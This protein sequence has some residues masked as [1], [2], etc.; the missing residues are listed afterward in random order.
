MSQLTQRRLLLQSILALPLA[1]CGGGGGGGEGAL[2]SERVL[3]QVS[4]QPAGSS[5]GAIPAVD[6]MVQQQLLAQRIP[7]ASL[8]VARSGRIV[9]AKGYGYAD[10]EAATP[11][12]VE[13]R[14]EIG[15][16]TKSF[17]ASA[18]MLLVEDGLLTLDDR[19]E[20]YLGATPAAWNGITIRHLLNHSSGLPEYPD[21]AFFAALE[22]DQGFS[23]AELLARFKTHG[24]AFPPGSSF[25]YSNTG[26]DL[27]GLIIQ[28]V[29]G[30][31]Y[32]EFLRR[33][34]F[35]PLGMDSARL[36][37]PNES[38]A[39]NAIG[40]EIVAEQRRPHAYNSA[41][42]NYLALAASGLQ[43]NALDMAKWDAALYTERILKRATL[44]LMWTPNSLMQAAN[45]TTPDIW[46]GL[47]W[48]LRTQQGHRWVYHSGGMPGHVVDFIRYPDDQLTVIVMT[49]LDERHANARVI[50]RTVAQI[51][52]PGL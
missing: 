38:A 29:S 13:Q 17:A 15:S 23:T 1:G 44:D 42:R 20:P 24:L 32:G 37:A 25:L 41:E 2:A 35:Q 52:Q 45:A 43:I 51:I 22:R 50:A 40:Y 10:L 19:L 3:P 26:Y 39:G 34:V 6:D 48:Q 21:D 5:Q 18:I 9:Y 11:I 30:Q 14:F 8:V 33:R 47:G 12:Q 36:M 16:V 46:Y 28:K 7:G 49:N 27:I 4:T 31:H